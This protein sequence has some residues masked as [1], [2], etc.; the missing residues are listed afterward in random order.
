MKS[1]IKNF[2]L[3]SAVLKSE[4]DEKNIILGYNS[5]YILN[6]LLLKLYIFDYLRFIFFFYD[7]L[8]GRYCEIF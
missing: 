5:G 7:Y 8:S 3:C 6:K 1:L 2:V 4:Y